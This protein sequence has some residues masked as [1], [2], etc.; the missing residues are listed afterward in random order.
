M[1]NLISKENK[2][3]TPIWEFS[4]E[5]EPPLSKCERACE[6]VFVCRCRSTLLPLHVLPG[7]CARTPPTTRLCTGG[8]YNASSR[9]HVLIVVTEC[10]GANPSRSAL[11]A[12]PA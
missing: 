1:K 9:R 3:L 5:K 11:I 7:Q 12:R 4:Y 10:D 6:A 2:R 8:L